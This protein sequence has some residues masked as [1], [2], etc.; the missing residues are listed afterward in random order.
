MICGLM[1]ILMLLSSSVLSIA[2]SGE[3]I[4]G[5]PGSWVIGAMVNRRIPHVA[6]WEFA[7]LGLITYPSSLGNI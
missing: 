3:D 4:P 1:F 2:F 6:L 7:F 5:T